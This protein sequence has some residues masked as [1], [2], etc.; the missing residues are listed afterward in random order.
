M[1]ETPEA[2]EGTEGEQPQ[3]AEPTYQRTFFPTDYMRFAATVKQV[4][5]DYG[6]DKADSLSAVIVEQ[7][8]NDN[9]DFDVARFRSAT[10]EHPAY[11]GRLAGHLRQARH[12]KCGSAAKADPM[13]VGVDNMEQA[14]GEWLSEDA[15]FDAGVFHQNAA[16][17]GDRYQR[18]G[19][20]GM[21]LS[22]GDEDD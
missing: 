9:P 11:Y 15:N 21:G 22:G 17:P 4:R 2:P 10:V 12:V 3:D 6:D 14:L 5:A 19:Y 20:G 1:S 8:S 7:L 13:Q 16:H 18:A